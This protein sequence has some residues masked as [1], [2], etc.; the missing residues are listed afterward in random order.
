MYTENT[1][2]VLIFQFILLGYIYIQYIAFVLS[3]SR[4]SLFRN[5]CFGGLVCSSS[6]MDIEAHCKKTWSIG[7]GLARE[8]H[9]F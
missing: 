4:M 3:N 8:L 5:D 7:T 9:G 2:S 6:R 1:H